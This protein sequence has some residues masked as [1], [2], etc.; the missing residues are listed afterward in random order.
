MIKDPIT[1]KVEANVKDAISIMKKNHIGGIPIINDATDL[2]GI[3]TNRD[4]RF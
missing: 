2:I 4:L 1:L 3:V